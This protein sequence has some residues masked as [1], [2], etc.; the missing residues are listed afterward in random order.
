MYIL[1][2]F[3]KALFTAT[4]AIAGWELGKKMAE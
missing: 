3:I 4:L 1:I 2:E